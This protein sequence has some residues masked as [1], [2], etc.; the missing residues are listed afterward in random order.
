MV[1]DEKSEVFAICSLIIPSSKDLQI[2]LR[3]RLHDKNEAP[4]DKSSAC[5]VVEKHKAEHLKRNLTR[6]KLLHQS[7]SNSKL[8]QT[9]MDKAKPHVLNN[10]ILSSH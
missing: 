4:Y 2:L 3:A 9:Y 7:V 6:F 1:Y 5:F 8:W 10:L